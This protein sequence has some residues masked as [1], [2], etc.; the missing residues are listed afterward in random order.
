MKMNILLVNKFLHPNG[1]SET[2]MFQL[3]EYLERIGHKVQYFGMDHPNRIV[4]NA[5]DAYTSTMDFHS[6]SGLAKV[7][8]AFRTIYSKE[9]RKKI[10]IVL[11]DFK[12]DVVHINNFNYQLTPSIIVEV[13]KWKKERAHKCRI[14]Y[15]AHD[16]QLVCPNHQLF[17]P[18]TGKICEKCL[19]GGNR[20]FF[21]CSKGKCIHSSGVRSMIGSCE[22]FYWNNRGIYRDLDAIICPSQ[23]MKE[24]L[25]T[26]PVLASK[27]VFLRNFQTDN[28][29]LSVDTAS[30]PGLPDRY[31]LYFGRFSTEK[32]ISTL[33]KAIKALPD[34]R[35]VLAGSGPLKDQVDGIPNVLNAG[36]L[37]GGVLNGVIKNASFSVIPSEWFEN[38][39]YSVIESL[40]LGTPVLGARI[41][42]IPELIRDGVTGE[43]FTSGDPEELTGKIRNLWDHADRVDTYRKNCRAIGF[44]NVE[45][46]TVKLLP[47][48]EG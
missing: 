15:T 24:K 26:N 17:N 23:F 43:L 14:I 5:S 44:D 1:G 28:P 16:F 13:M 47:I 22:A 29:N 34:I 12:P 37:S 4:G 30:L 18:N 27:T 10:R 11:E 46:Y 7:S 9:A 35:F 8:Y 36:F 41:G 3:G 39:P 38:C 48:Y 45:A 20:R 42:G 33:L 6:C 40:M 32:G 21:N 19:I 31:V 25:D 2:Y